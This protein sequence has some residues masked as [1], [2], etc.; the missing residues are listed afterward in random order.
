MAI[1]SLHQVLRKEV[2][3]IANP[4]IIIKNFI[5]RKLAEFIYP[6]I[7]ILISETYISAASADISKYVNDLRG[8]LNGI[9]D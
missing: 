1:I 8:E 7:S 3:K 9:F 5:K 4:F 6:E 2:S